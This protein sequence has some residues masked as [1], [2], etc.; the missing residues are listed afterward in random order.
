M[1]KKPDRD[2]VSAG[3]DRALSG[4]AG[5]DTPIKRAQRSASEP[6]SQTRQPGES[7]KR[8]PSAARQ[9]ERNRRRSAPGAR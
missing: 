7:R 4:L 9:M 5:Q 2:S 1:A 3:I 8:R 6:L